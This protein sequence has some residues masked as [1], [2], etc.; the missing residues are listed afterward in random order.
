MAVPVDRITIRSSRPWI[1]KQFL[2]PLLAITL[3]ACG[4]QEAAVCDPPPEAGKAGLLGCVHRAAYE[5]ANESSS[6][7]DLVRLAVSECSVQLDRDLDRAQARIKFSDS[8][9]DQFRDLIR[10]SAEREA[11]NRFSEARAGQCQ[12]V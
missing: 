7:L 2:C 3:A 4:T 1:W 10:K 6:E 11:L 12:F 5:F 9:R 8:H